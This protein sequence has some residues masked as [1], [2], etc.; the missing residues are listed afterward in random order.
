MKHQRKG[1]YIPNQVRMHACHLTSKHCTIVFE[2][3]QEKSSIRSSNIVEKERSIALMITKNW[4]WSWN[5]KKMR[6]TLLLGKSQIKEKINLAIGKHRVFKPYD[7]ELSG[8][9]CNQEALSFQ[10]LRSGIIKKHQVFRPFS[11]HPFRTSPGKS[12]F[13]H[14]SHHIFH[15][16]R[17][18]ITMRPHS[19]FFPSGRSPVIMRPSSSIW[20]GHPS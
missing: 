12:H 1:T 18:P 16:G 20:E 3:L 19:T 10:T 17:S 5:K 8:Q 4:F 2:L 13:S 9:P 15:L 14:L 6:W 7:E 11:C